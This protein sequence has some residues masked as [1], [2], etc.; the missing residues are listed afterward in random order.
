MCYPNTEVLPTEAFRVL[1]VHGDSIP[2]TS[3]ISYHM[4]FSAEA[5]TL[6]CL[7]SLGAFQEAPLQKVFKIVSTFP[8]TYSNF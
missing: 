5:G 8:L 6:Q 1:A 3:L 7:L 4:P 2:A